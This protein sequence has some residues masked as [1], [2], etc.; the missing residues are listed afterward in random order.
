M[1]K[2]PYC[3]DDFS[4]ENFFEVREYETKRGKIKTKEHFKGGTKYVGRPN[5][6]VRMWA[7]PGCDTILGFSEFAYI[8]RS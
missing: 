3:K 1:S 5:V 2:C 8:S 7:C 6:N 4:I